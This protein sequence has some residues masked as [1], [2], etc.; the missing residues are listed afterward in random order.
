MRITSKGQVTIP[1]HIRREARLLP[2]TEV[3]FV[4]EDGKVV[5]RQA[6]GRLDQIR[7]RIRSMRG[8]GTANLHM[9]TDE[10]ME[11]MRG[12]WEDLP[13]APVSVQEEAKPFRP[14]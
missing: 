2:D 3:E 8:A 5:L 6:A 12:P 4:I 7:S 1:A 14:K 11:M 9:T 13:D 10:I